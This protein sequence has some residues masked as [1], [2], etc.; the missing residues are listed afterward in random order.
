MGYFRVPVSFP[1]SGSVRLQWSYPSGFTFL[2][3]YGTAVVTSRTETI[4]IH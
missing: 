4:T 2:P 1:S 3:P